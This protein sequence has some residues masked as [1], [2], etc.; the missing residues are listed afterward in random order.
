MDDWQ[1]TRLRCVDQTALAVRHVWCVGRNYAA[2][3]REMGASPEQEVPLFFSKPAVCLVQQSAIAY[4]TST[5]SLH[6]EAELAVILGQGG[7]NLAPEQVDH[8]IQAWAVSCDLTRR[9]VQARA[10]QA[11]HPWEMAKAFDQSAP[12]GPCLPASEWR[13]LPESRIRLAVNQ[14]TRQSAQLG[15]MIW[16]VPSLISRLSHEVTLH[17]G[18]VV[19]TG[20]PAGV[21]PLSVGDDVRVEVEG[22]P[23]LQFHIV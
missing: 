22:L 2:H 13:P 12:I 16:D 1:P 15:E 4:P 18:D 6:H 20:T 3:A 21:G 14:Q 9:D 8:C 11:G 17:S 23:A 19:L 10:K 5:D 7:R